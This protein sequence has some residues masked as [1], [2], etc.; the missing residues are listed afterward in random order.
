[1]P[2][3]RTHHEHALRTLIIGFARS[4]FDADAAYLLA[5]PRDGFRA[6]ISGMIVVLIWAAGARPRWAGAGGHAPRR[7]APA[8]EFR[9]SSHRQP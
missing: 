2:W 7:S 9:S 8:P 3:A 6:F 5:L 4:G 1:M